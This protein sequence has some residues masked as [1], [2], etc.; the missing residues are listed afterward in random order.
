MQRQ[1]AIFLKLKEYI[2][3]ININSDKIATVDTFS[4][5][6]SSQKLMSLFLGKENVIGYYWFFIKNTYLKK[7]QII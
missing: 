4:I 6:L 3:Y 7:V 5:F 1:I 2:N